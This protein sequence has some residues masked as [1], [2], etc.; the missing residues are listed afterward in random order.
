MIFLVAGEGPSDIGQCLNYRSRCSGVDFQAGP[1]AVMVRQIVDRELNKLATGWELD[2]D[3]V[4]F[5]HHSEFATVE[6][7]KAQPTSTLL[8]G[9]KAKKE[10]DDIYY[11]QEA[12]ILG[13]LAK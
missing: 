5:V 7:P 11:Y 3:A 1:L 9:K 2:A 4:E 13:Y 6:L 10:T 12:R 8:P